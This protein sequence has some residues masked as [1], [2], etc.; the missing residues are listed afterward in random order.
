M[1]SHKRFTSTSGGSCGVPAYIHARYSPKRDVYLRSAGARGATI[2]CGATITALCCT[3]LVVPS[4]KKFA[5][6][7]GG[8][9]RVPAYIHARHSP[10]RDGYLPVGLALLDTAQCNARDSYLR[11]N[12]LRSV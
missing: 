3:C 12:S 6:T 2:T 5:C 4:H 11:W 8:S 9:C 1:P 10:E 7:S